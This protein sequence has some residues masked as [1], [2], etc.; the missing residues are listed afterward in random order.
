MAEPIP[1]PSVIMILILAH[2]FYGMAMPPQLASLLVFVCLGSIG[3]LNHF[4][5]QNPE[6]HARR[7]DAR[8]STTSPT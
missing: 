1:V 5:N 2:Q 3:Q 6:P 4:H 7:D 8:P